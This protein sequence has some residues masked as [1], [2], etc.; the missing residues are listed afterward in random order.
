[1]S[2]DV[3][4]NMA[5]EKTSPQAIQLVKSKHTKYLSRMLKVLPECLSSMETTR[6][7]LVYFC[8]SAL[9]VL[10]EIDK[11]LSPEDKASTIKWIYSLQVCMNILFREMITYQI[12][13]YNPFPIVVMKWLYPHFRSSIIRNTTQKNYAIPSAMDFE[14]VRLPVLKMSL[15]NI[16]MLVAEMM[17]VKINAM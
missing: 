4:D 12:T 10:E 9:D 7:T 16:Q 3:N 8:I 2:Q 11:V 5:A 1:M 17:T 15:I 13:Y 6:M 14:V